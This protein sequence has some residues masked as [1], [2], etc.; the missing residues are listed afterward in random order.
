MIRSIL[1]AIA[2]YIA[3]A[4]FLLLGS[5][6]LLGPRR[7][8][9]MGLKAHAIACCWLLRLIVGTRL[10]VR[11]RENLP[12]GAVL[13][14]AKHQSAWDTFGLVP[15]FRDPALVMKA[16]LFRIP[17]YGW[18]SRKFGMVEVRRDKRSAAM[19]QLLVDTKDRAE[20]GREIVIFPEGTRTAPGAEPDFKPGLVLLYEG[21][22]LP[23]VPMAINSGM[24]WPRRVWRRYPGTI[25]VEFLPAIPPGVPRKVFKAQVEGAIERATSRLV[26]EARAKAAS[27]GSVAPLSAEALARLEATAGAVVKR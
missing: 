1:F 12:D 8:A 11:G 13:V 16:E 18:F 17:L 22:G 5:P 23:C 19:R 7:W 10:E 14:A 4:L 15:L 27:P 21:L 3:T 26:L 2:F 9:M 25:V 24:F 20:A 6:L